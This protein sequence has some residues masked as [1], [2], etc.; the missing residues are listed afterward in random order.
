MT[1]TTTRELVD[2]AASH[3]T[4]VPAFNVISLEHAEGVV[5]GIES[6][7]SS[8]LLQISEN[9]A[10]FHGGRFAPLVAA[11]AQIASHSTAAI[12]IHLDHFRSIDLLEEAIATASSLGA[13]SIMV[14]AAHLD[15]GDNISRTTSLTRDAHAAGLWVEAELGEIGGK[16]G[17]VLD[18]H[19]PGARTDPDDAAAFV[20]ATGVDALAVAVGSSHAMSSRTAQLDIDLLSRLCGRVSVP[21][22]LHGSSGVPDD[23]IRSAVDAGIRKVNVGT[24]LNLSFTAAVRGA[25]RAEPSAHD[26]RTYLSAGRAAV[27]E[28]VA[29]F[30]RSIDSVRAVSGR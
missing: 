13:T 16:D 8:A 24:A 20:A 5:D 23:M 25:M 29:H 18:A 1:L 2:S 11:C 3:G 19:A 30:C 26:P 6:A 7:G 15:Y 4:A 21:L 14:D 27:S 28:T 17:I 22:V 10:L 9:T 12:A